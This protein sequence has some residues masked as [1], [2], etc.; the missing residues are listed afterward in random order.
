[1]A[2]ISIPG[3]TD[4]YGTN[5]TIE[6]LMAVER[7]PLIREQEKLETYKDQQNNWRT[8]N[9]Q[10]SSLRESARQLYSFDNPFNSKLAESSQPDAIEATPN[11]NASIGSFSIRV[12]QIA[13]SDRFLSGNIEKNYQVPEGK[14][15]FKVNDKSVSFNWK[16]GKVSDFVTSLN[17]RGNNLIKASLIGVSSKEQALM[18]ESLKTGK[19]NQLVFEDAALDLALDTNIVED[20]GINRDTV[21]V[22]N[23]SDLSK[24]SG[25]VFAAVRINNGEISVPAKNGFE[26]K[27]ADSVSGN[28]ANEINFSVLLESEEESVS[29]EEESLDT[30][31]QQEPFGIQSEPVLP[32]SPM[33][34]FKGII[35]YNESSEFSLPSSSPFEQEENDLPAVTIDSSVVYLKTAEGKEIPL[36]KIRNDNEKQDFTVSLSEYPDAQSI[37]IKNK[38]SEKTVHVSFPVATDT[39]LQANGFEPL[40]PIERADDA[41]IRYEGITMYRSE[42][43]IDDIV[44]DIT[45]NLLDTTDKNAKITITPDVE[46]SKEA[47]ISLVGNYNRVLAEINILTQNKPEIVTE[48]E[49][50]DSDEQEAAMNRLGTFSTESS[51]TTSKSSLQRIIANTYP[52]PDSSVTMLSQIGISTNAASG[53]T[54]YNA[55]RLRGYL[56]INEETLDKALENQIDDIKNLFGYDSDGDL[57]IDTG[58][59]YLMEQHLQAYVQTGGI[60]ATRISNLDSKISSSESTISSLE[61]KLEDKER[62]YRTKFGNMESSLASLESQS[63]S[64]TNFI[65]QQNNSRSR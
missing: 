5:S 49:Y 30:T 21:L 32:D 31:S 9:K 7:T 60:I 37:V 11:R 12:D 63:N 64:I 61:T 41:K 47:I 51:L 16:G 45:L 33:I 13:T 20:T 22:K 52:I 17:R 38:N 10:M 50:F 36:D 54:G 65:N 35:V 6:K 15:T 56:E 57:I 14:Y 59:A 34:N 53:S 3:V 27:L 39:S 23:S 43:T 46:T 55:S 8:I 44:P 42:N 4:K 18:I 19:E 2:D 1:M 25:M 40:N 26:L 24:T 29:A 58:I 28:S 48:L 62:E